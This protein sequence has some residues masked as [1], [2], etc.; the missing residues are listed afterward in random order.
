MKKTVSVGFLFLMILLL[1][2]IA[3]VNKA[4]LAV[5]ESENFFL[6]LF[7]VPQNIIYANVM[8]KDLPNILGF[9]DYKIR[10]GIY[11]DTINGLTDSRIN[12]TKDSRIIG[13]KERADEIIIKASLDDSFSDNNLLMPIP[14]DFL[15][16]VS[17]SPDSRLRDLILLKEKYDKWKVKDDPE[18]LFEKELYYSNKRVQEFVKFPGINNQTSDNLISQYRQEMESALNI[19]NSL[20]N[21]KLFTDYINYVKWQKEIII[22]SIG[23]SKWKSVFENLEKETENFK[24]NRSFD[25]SRYVF[26]IPKKGEYEIFI[27]NINGLTNSEKNGGWVKL[28]ERNF[29]EGEQELTLPFSGISENLVDENLEINNYLP[30]SIYRINFN[31]QSSEDLTLSIKE[32]DSDKEIVRMMVYPTNGRTQ[33]FEAFFKSSLEGM[34]VAIHFI[35]NSDEEIDLEYTNLQV[36]RIYEPEVML[37]N[38]KYPNFV[39]NQAP[40]ISNIKYQT[41]KITFVKINPTK[42]RVK[43]EGAKDPYTLIFSESFHEGWK[44]YING[45]KNDGLTD[46]ELKNYGE[47]VASY[48]GGDIK[49]G[50][51]RNT[52]LE[53]A[54]FETLGKKPISEDKHL[55]V[56]GYANSWYITPED[57]G[58]KQD[59]E[60]IIEFAPQ[61]LFYIGLFISLLTL[62]SCL[63][64]IMF[65]TIKKL[66]KRNS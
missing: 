25:E 14:A 22:N 35:N 4:V 21:E 47:T 65:S 59:Y 53:K 27:K 40:L 31:Y 58:G 51:H 64:Y 28:G 23:L 54:T 38:I 66:W 8:A 20:N 13:L 45:L 16:Y 3:G 34:S 29:G 18:K 52:F 50:T 49:E 37:K 46:Y 57:A 30:N 11:L 62:I 10:S 15:P 2:K 63:G 32:N 24:A 44:M 60:L 36:N 61:R 48:F 33:Q 43:I 6:P 39:R 5:S 9:E 17:Q 12:E 56:N 7:Y 19:A 1:G 55:L 42:Y 26:E 41:P